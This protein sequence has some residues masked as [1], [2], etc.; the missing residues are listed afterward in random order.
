MVSPD[1]LSPDLGSISPW[2]LA[3]A[4]LGLMAVALLGLQLLEPRREV[5]QRWRLPGYLQAA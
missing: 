4:P 5:P 2:L 3:V 1:L